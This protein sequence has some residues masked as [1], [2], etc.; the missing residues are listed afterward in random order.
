MR[1]LE[2][3]LQIYRWPSQALWRDLEVAALKK[4]QFDRPVLEIGCGSGE[5]TALVLPYVDEAIDV[6]PS[7]VERCRRLCPSTYGRVR[8]LDA[9]RLDVEEA[10]FST[11]LANCVFEHIPDLDG[12]LRGCHS[13]LLPG[14]RLVATVPLET[15]NRHLL[16]RWNWY[17]R[18]RQRQLSHRNLWSLEEWSRRL[19]QAGF[20][21]IRAEPY[22]TGEACRYWDRWDVV[23]CAGWGRFQFGGIFA[24]VLFAALPLRIQ[25]GLITDWAGRLEALKVRAKGT[26][27][28]CAVLVTAKK[29]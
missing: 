16:F 18:L 23:A 25:R 17:A 26:R 1:T 22:L 15:M 13:A 12:V 4:A 11:V 10:R 21:E 5:L 2:Q 14:G 3:L 24:R 8:C 6:S 20:H 27:D 9:R 7:A 28:A 29:P 19:E